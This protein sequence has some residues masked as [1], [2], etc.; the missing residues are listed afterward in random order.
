MMITDDY[1]DEVNNDDEVKR[2][3]NERSRQ[4]ILLNNETMNKPDTCFC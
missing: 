1:E 2:E 3:I 4:F